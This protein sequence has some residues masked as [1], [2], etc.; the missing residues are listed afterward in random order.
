MTQPLVNQPGEVWEYGINI[1]W[2][3]IL[4]ERA[5]G[6]RLNDYFLKNILEPMGI[7]NISESRTYV[8]QGQD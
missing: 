6:M 3:G 4:V 2:A 1:D 7:K 8:F 5:S